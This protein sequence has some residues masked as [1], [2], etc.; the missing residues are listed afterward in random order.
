MKFL[1][2]LRND[3][4]YFIVPALFMYESTAQLFYHMLKSFAFLMIVPRK[5]KPWNHGKADKPGLFA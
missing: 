1:K 4:S 3:M 5:A 2:R